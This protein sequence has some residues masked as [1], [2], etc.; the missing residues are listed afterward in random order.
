MGKYS[1]EAHA[2]LAQLG[3]EATPRAISLTAKWIRVLRETLEILRA[4]A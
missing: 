4:E 1:S 2:V 3:I